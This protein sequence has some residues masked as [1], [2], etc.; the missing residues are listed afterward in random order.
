MTILIVIGLFVVAWTPFIVLGILSVYCRTCT[1][2]WDTRI[3]MATKLLHYSN[4][5]V[6]PIIYAFRN[7]QFQRSFQAILSCH[8]DWSRLEQES[9]SGQST[10]KTEYVELT[11][12]K[13]NNEVNV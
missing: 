9:K 6:N 1:F 2:L 7:S 11:K 4:S 3:T 5:A 12:A 10:C 13:K 8:S